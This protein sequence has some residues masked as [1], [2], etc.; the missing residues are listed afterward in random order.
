MMARRIKLLENNNRN[1]KICIQTL[2]Y[3]LR[4]TIL[5]SQQRSVVTLLRDFSKFVFVVFNVTDTYQRSIGAKTCYV[6]KCS[7]FK[8]CVSNVLIWSFSQCVS[9]TSFYFTEN[10]P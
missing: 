1:N 2:T 7:L 10:I 4:Q 3:T 6:N 9:H 5:R 8:C